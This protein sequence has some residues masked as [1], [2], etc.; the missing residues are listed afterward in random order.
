MSFA[1][2]T[3]SGIRLYTIMRTQCKD[4][5]VSLSQSELKNESY[6]ITII[7]ENNNL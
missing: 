5:Y 1:K 6:L 4:K 3:T 2:K 7:E